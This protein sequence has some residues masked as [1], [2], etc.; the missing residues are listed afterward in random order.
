MSRRKKI[1]IIII[2]ILA[3]LILIACA[4]FIIYVNDYYEAIDI[5]EY[6]A[7]SDSVD[8]KEGDDN[9]YF[10]PKSYDSGII[11][12]PGAKVEEEAYAPICRMLAEEG[13]LVILLH[14]P[15]NL[16]FF[17]SDRAE[18]IID[19][20]QDI[21]FYLMGHSLGGAMSSSYLASNSDKYEGMILLASYSTKSLRNK[22]LDVLSIYGSNDKVL[23]K[24][25]Y[26]KN[27]KNLPDDYTE[28][29][30]DGG[31][32]GYFGS[33]GNQDNDGIATIT[34]LTQWSITVTVIDTFIS[35]N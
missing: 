2:S 12:Y 35:E 17:D 15:F 30:I 18:D 27:K 14:M 23:N 8:V 1:G 20:Y 5:D 29:I 21:D 7:S 10:I 11:M 33:Y 3:G 16:A 26:N 6:L 13:Y 32:H 9:Y 4:S 19:D 28:Y 34:Q 24:S 31:N 22:D 25:N